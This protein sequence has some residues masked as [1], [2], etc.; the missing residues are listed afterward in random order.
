MERF[1]E[2]KVWLKGLDN[3]QTEKLK[4]IFEIVN[5]LTDVWVSR[6]M[7]GYK[8]RRLF[9][10]PK[11]KNY[12]PF[13]ADEIFKASEK[14]T[15]LDWIQDWRDVYLELADISTDLEKSKKE[16]EYSNFYGWSID[17]NEDLPGIF[18][19]GLFSVNVSDEYMNVD[20]DYQNT[21]P[22]DFDYNKLRDVEKV[23]EFLARFVYLVILVRM[24]VTKVYVYEPGDNKNNSKLNFN[25]LFRPEF[26]TN[27]PREVI[28]LLGPGEADAWELKNDKKVWIYDGPE[29]SIMTPFYYLCDL[30]YIEVPP[31]KKNE[32]V[33]VWLKEF[34]KDYR[35]KTFDK[36]PLDYNSK[37]HFKEYLL[38]LK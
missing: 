29:S 9:A 25:R 6:L 30:G 13:L 32:F 16:K 20:I 11:Y 15:S 1:K 14:L 18:I 19:H 33:A 21:S 28:R 4:F 8:I 5:G 26:R 22:D 7:E 36:A 37:E 2:Y 31:R 3:N 17:E 24:L 27:I 35:A 34:G 10:L 23:A 38:K 12:V